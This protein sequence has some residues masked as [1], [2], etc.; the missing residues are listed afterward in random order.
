[1]N[2]NIEPAVSITKKKFLF[3]SYDG[4]ISDVAWQT[5]KEGHNVKYYIS[6]SLDKDSADGLVPKVDNWEKEVD[7]A[8]IIVFDDVLGMGKWAEKLRK[9]GKLVVG[10]TTYSDQLEDDRS[11]GQEE[12]KK[13]GIPIIPYRDFNDFNE[14]IDYVKNNPCRYVIKP[15]GEAQNTKRFLFVG[16]EDDGKD[17]IQVLTA[18]QRL[19][20]DKIKVFQLQKRIAGVEVAIGAFFNGNEFVYPVNINFEHKKLFPGNIGPATGEMG[21]SMFWTGPN[22]FF[23]ATLKKMEQ[24]L[25]EE[26][27]V[28]YIDINCIV[29]NNGIYPLEFTAR[30]GYPAIHIQQEGILMPTSDFLYGLASGEL[31]KF[32]ARSGF[33]IGVRLVVPPFPYGGEVKRSL[34]DSR[35]AV[36]FFKKPKMEG[37][38]IEDVKLINNEWVVA[39]SSGVVFVVVGTGQTMKQAQ[40]QAYSRISNIM[41]PNMFYR[42]DIG[43]RWFEDSDKLHNWGYLREL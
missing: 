43:D 11:F 27:Y 3:V 41:L 16:E 4:L 30:F 9:Q 8:D 22:R 19:W 28:G 35:E 42:D 39:C 15:S 20:S 13:Y 23:N 33:Q 21:T 1:M 34:A 14:A 37:I 31:K 18:Y 26:H 12:L 32:K 29:N 5:V 7:W 2:N 6:N 36:V 10:G 38:H 25:Q 24:K 40:S 17:V